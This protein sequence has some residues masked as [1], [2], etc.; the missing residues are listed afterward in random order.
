[1]VI[2]QVKWRNKRDVRNLKLN[3]IIS[4]EKQK[5]YHLYIININGIFKSILMEMVCIIKA[6]DSKSGIYYN[7]TIY[8][9]TGCEQFAII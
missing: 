6:K 2:Y 1:M 4:K 3:C 8:F 9:S 5:Y 7:Y